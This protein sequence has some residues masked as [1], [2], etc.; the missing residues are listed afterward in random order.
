MQV[1]AYFPYNLNYTAPT[2]ASVA[3]RPRGSGPY[4]HQFNQRMPLPSVIP[5]YR[6]SVSTLGGTIFTV[7]FFVTYYVTFS[8]YILKFET[9]WL[10]CAPSGYYCTFQTLWWLL[11]IIGTI[12]RCRQFNKATTRR[13]L[14]GI[15]TQRFICCR[16][17][18]PCHLVIL[19]GSTSRT[20]TCNIGNIW[21][22]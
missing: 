6:W 21:L 1:P 8:A 13:Y 18:I 15:S 7:L 20:F 19:D 9:N 14:P 3:S 22:S 4:S 5:R 2:F 12:S 10:A 16:R 17:T 11:E